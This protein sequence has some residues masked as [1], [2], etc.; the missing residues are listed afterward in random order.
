MRRTRLA[1]QLSSTHTRRRQPHDLRQPPDGAAPKRPAGTRRQIDLTASKARRSSRARL[2]SRLRRLP[3]LPRLRRLQRRSARRAK[4][5]R[6]T[7]LAECALR[8]PR[9]RARLAIRRRPPAAGGSRELGGAGRADRVARC[10]PVRR[11]ACAA[12]VERRSSRGQPA[13]RK[14]LSCRQPQAGEH[15]IGS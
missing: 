4:V 14:A 7:P 5:S 12:A 11:S 6:Q 15:W 8:S 10:H 3:H 9:S 1:H 2:L 13:S